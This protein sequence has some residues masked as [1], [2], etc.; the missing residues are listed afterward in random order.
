MTAARAPAGAS[1]RPI[2]LLRSAWDESVAGRAVAFVRRSAES[3]LLRSALTAWE[4]SWVGSLGKAV[5]LPAGAPAAPGVSLIVPGLVALALLDA[6]AFNLSGGPAARAPAA[7]LTVAVAAA[8]PQMGLY[9]FLTVAPLA[10][11]I[12]ALATAAAVVLSTAARRL[13]AASW[14]PGLFAADLTREL[15]ERSDPALALLAGL[16]VAATAT[17]VAPAGSLRYLAVWAL[18]FG[19]YWATTGLLRRAEDLTRAAL[20]FGLSAVL[21]GLYGLYQVAVHVPAERAWIGAGFFPEMGTRVFAFWGNPNVFALHLLLAGP[22]LAA[23]LWTAGSRKA[24]VVVGLGVLTAGLALVLTLSRAG[25]FGFGVAVLF[26][27]VVRDRRIL[28]VGLLAAL[29]ALVIAPDVVLSRAATLTR[30]DDPTAVHRVRIWEASLRM[31]EDFWYSGLGLSW[32]AFTTIYP[33]YAIEGR[34]AF[35]AH[36]HYLQT[37][38][39][40]GVIGFAAV[41]WVLLR[42]IGWA[43]RLSGR[44]RVRPAG[45]L[46]AGAAAAVLASLA[47]GLAEPIFYLPRPILLIWF[48][49]GLAT[50]ARAAL[51]NETR[52]GRP[53]PASGGGPCPR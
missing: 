27:G 11:D 44:A 18:G 47:F 20:A 8:S 38:I 16:L 53:V 26:L 42:P 49:L 28:A 37:L 19:L 46:L 33:Q 14:R 1:A 39:E 9:A 23:V 22:L 40:L 4:E 30:F 50:A 25:W 41:H 43:V 21:S 17:S 7:A 31:V 3:G 52:P 35:H 29:A 24:R 13:A 15:R 34:F 6:W 45:S 32:R 10:G 36:S 5:W 48:V 2:V 51:E 12:L